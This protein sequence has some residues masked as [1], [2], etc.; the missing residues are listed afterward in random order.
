MKITRNK[1]KSLVK[2]CLVEILSE[3]IGDSPGTL[4]ESKSL[5]NTTPAPRGRTRKRKSAVD[6]IK[7][8]RRVNEAVSSM[9]Q[10]PTMAAIFADTAK[11]TL[12]DQNSS[13]S[14][15]PIIQPGSDA[16]ARAAAVHN[17]EDLF[18]GATNW[19]TLAFDD[20]PKK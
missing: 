14:R 1:L 7:F 4:V 17:P 3:G 16:A 20:S 2:E 10:D 6:N 19:A 8:D 18:E 9:T 13:E 11:T 5:K 12:Q 15:T